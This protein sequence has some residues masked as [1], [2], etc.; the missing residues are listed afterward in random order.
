MNIMNSL[1]LPKL[2]QLKSYEEA[3][4]TKFDQ[5]LPVL[6]RKES[7][8]L[9]DPTP[10]SLCFTL[11]H[12]PTIL[13][14]IYLARYGL[15]WLFICLSRSTNY[16]ARIYMVEVAFP[17][18]LCNSGYTCTKLWNYFHYYPSLNIYRYWY[19]LLDTDSCLYHM[20]S[21]L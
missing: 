20:S 9:H 1:K 6:T 19:H 11:L 7:S 18:P 2:P 21:Q 17:L 15:G 3:I 8:G 13:Q 14:N 5:F 4:S 16:F 12:G 10:H